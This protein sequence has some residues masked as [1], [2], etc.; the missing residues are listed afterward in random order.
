[1]PLPPDP[2][3]SPK[4]LEV[5]LFLINHVEVFGF[6]PSQ[7]EMADALGIS[8]SAIQNRLRECERRGLVRI[9][10]HAERAVQVY[11]VRYSAYQCDSAP[12]NLDLQKVREETKQSLQLLKT[13]A[14]VELGGTTA[15]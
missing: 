10:P 8:K 13:Q 1:M 15:K 5:I 6:Q 4:Q 9:N 3:P 2:N 11:N 14:E 7:Q 12:T